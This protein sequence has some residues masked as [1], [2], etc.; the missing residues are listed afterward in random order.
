[1]LV[2]PAQMRTVLTALIR[3]AIEAAPPAGWARLS[4]EQTPNG[5]ALVMEDSGPGP[6]LADREHLFDP[7]YSGRK[8]GRGRGLGL[9]TAWQLARLHGGLVRFD[10]TEP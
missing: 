7:F 8:A 6:T 1:L 3:N 4:I 10:G 5:L 9:S 2:D